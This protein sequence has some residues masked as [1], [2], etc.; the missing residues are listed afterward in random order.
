M[1]KGLNGIRNTGE[2]DR[3]QA[4]RKQIKTRHRDSERFFPRINLAELYDR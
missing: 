3:Q 4:E 2:I 1:T